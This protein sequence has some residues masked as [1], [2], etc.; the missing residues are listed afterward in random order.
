MPATPI[1]NLAGSSQA[2][3]T[4]TPQHVMIVG[5][6]G[7]QVIPIAAAS[8][9]TAIHLPAANTQAT[10]TRAAA[11]AGIRNVCTGLT[12]IFAA[13]ATAP[14][15]INVAVNLIDGASGGGTYLWRA[16]L[17]LPATAGAVNGI[18]RQPLWIPG[19]ANTAMTLEFSV[20]GGANTIESVSM[21]GSTV[22]A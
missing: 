22:T 11:G 10:I 1:A 3:G 14:T 9:W 17:S 15:A 8:V 7:S 12:V 4:R 16:T 20:A 21:E 18:A 13:G 2:A 5:E 19:T 6:D